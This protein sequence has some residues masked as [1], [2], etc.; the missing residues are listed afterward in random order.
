MRKAFEI[1]VLGTSSATPTKY[2]HPSAHFVRLEG[3]YLLLDCGE[4]TQRQLARYGL[5]T[6][7]ISHVFITHL[8]GD[9]YFGLPGLISSMALFGRTEPLI[10]VGPAALEGIITSILKESDAHLPYLLKFIKTKTDA[11]HTLIENDKFA[12]VTVPLQHR[13]PCTG[14]LIK[15]LGPERHLNVDACI[16]YGVPVDQYEAIKRG[17]D[18]LSPQKGLIPNQHISLAGHPNRTLAYI[19]DTVYDTRLVEILRN[20]NLLYHEATFLHELKER[21][22]ETFHTTALQAG[23]IAKAAGV[24]ELLIGHFSARY[25]D[26]SLLLEEAQ[27]VF[28][29]TQEAVEGRTYSVL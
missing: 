22:A 25:N 13:M 6:L 23:Q 11:I 29:N 8:H 1:T 28:A 5:R 3:T 17:A 20:V 16:K 14:F 26:T 24:K 19:T 18:C 21:A 2:S 27:S 12:V 9:H 4:G 7:R 10:V 15:E